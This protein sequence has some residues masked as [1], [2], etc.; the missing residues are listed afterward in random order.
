MAKIYFTVTNDLSYDQRMIRICTS[1]AA[2]GYDVVLV[3]RKQK[4]SIPLK[5]MPFKQIRLSCLF[6]KGF[7]FY[8]FYNIKLFVFLLFKK[9]DGICAIDLDTIIPC[10]LVSTIK[11]KKRI[12]DAHELFCEMKEIAER[13]AIYKFW[14]FVERKTVPH[15]KNGY[16]V[17][18]VIAEEFKK[19]YGLNYEV[20][21]SI[22][23]FNPHLRKGKRERFLIYQGAVNE[24]RSFETLIP[25]MNFINA[26]LHIFGDGNFMQKALKLTEELNLKN[27]IIFHGMVSPDKL[28][29]YTSKAY[30]G[31]TLF[32]PGAKSN[33]FSLANRFF[34]YI[35]AATPQICV[36][37]PVYEKI[38]KEFEIAI[39]TNDISSSALSKSINDLLEDDV[40]WNRLHNNCIEASKILNWQNESVKLI[41]FY[42]NIFG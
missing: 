12:Y 34:H 9:M 6:E 18:E 29:K 36:A 16:T 37:Y 24:G 22:A 31:I 15:F 25:A 40:T 17:N 1:L 30:I 19:M 38:N 39:L 5:N 10:L 26:P 3:G 8:F 4:A 32:E 33:Y 14:K 23:E 11:G 21:R 35:Q 7:A 41:S 27:K 42:K 2:E 28:E 13:P 20:I